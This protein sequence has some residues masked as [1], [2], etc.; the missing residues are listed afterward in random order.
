M[1]DRHDSWR[2]RWCR[3]ENTRPGTTAFLVTVALV[4]GGMLVAVLIKYNALLF[5]IGVL[6]ALVV[7]Y[8]VVYAV[9]GFLAKRVQP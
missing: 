6:I 7:L 4:A 2:R 9:L 1:N 3:Y 5:T 8:G